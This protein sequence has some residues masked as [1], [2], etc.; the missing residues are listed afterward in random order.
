MRAVRRTLRIT[1]N[2][3][4]QRRNDAT[5]QVSKHSGAPTSGYSEINIVFVG[6]EF[7]EIYIKQY[8]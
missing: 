5:A 3:Q 4:K 7:K 1:A 8:S 2:S 6:K